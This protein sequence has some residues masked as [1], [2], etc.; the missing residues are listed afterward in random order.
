MVAKKSILIAAAA[1]ALLMGRMASAD[2]ITLHD[3]SENL[4]TGVFTYSV[5]LDTA[6]NVQSGDGFVLYDFP[7]LTSWSIAGTALNDGSAS[8]THQFTL[9]QTL[10]SNTLTQASSVDISA[11]AAAVSNGIS[12]DSASVT[13][14]S[15]S[16]NGPPTPFLGA[17][18]AVLTLTSGLKNGVIGNSVYGSVDHSGPNGNVPFSFSANPILIPT[19]APVPSAL[20]GGLA[21]LGL[22]GAGRM[23]KVRRIMG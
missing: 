15:F 9:S 2:T 22:V 12:F 8:P 23:I 21:L 18:T 14:L 20:L 13:N 17:T 6:A 16:Y 19:T 1:S 10:T 4:A 3:I 5:Q 7:Q 11:D